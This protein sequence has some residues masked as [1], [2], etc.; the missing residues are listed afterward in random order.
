MQQNFHKSTCS[1]FLTDR[2]KTIAD[3]E[4][5]K[6][7]NHQQCIASHASLKRGSRMG[8]AVSH[9]LTRTRNRNLHQFV[10]MRGVCTM[11]SRWFSPQS[12]S[13]SD[14]KKLMRLTKLMLFSKTLIKKLVAHQSM[15][16][17]LTLANTVRRSATPRHS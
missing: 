15:Q 10:R 12:M 9:K 17:L 13:L 7:A 2:N 14:S 1:C 5:S 6:S 16:T 8:L 3:Q 4:C 11:L